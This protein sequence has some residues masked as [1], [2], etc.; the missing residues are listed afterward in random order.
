MTKTIPLTY[1]YIADL[2]NLYVRQTNKI[3]PSLWFSAKSEYLPNIPS[4]TASEYCLSITNHP[5][6]LCFSSSQWEGM[7][8]LFLHD[9]IA[10]VVTLNNSTHR[11]TSSCHQQDR[12]HQTHICKSEAASCLFFS[13]GFRKW[14]E[15]L[16]T[17]IPVPKLKISSNICVKIELSCWSQSK[18]DFQLW[19][20]I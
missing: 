3:E 4:M 16:I 10:F 8:F 12:V 18:S 6:S 11:S 9:W 13:W 7:S 20:E 5:E 14:M 19:I 2:Q 15:S 1:V 17:G